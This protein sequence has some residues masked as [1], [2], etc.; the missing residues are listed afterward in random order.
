[1]LCFYGNLIMRRNSACALHWAFFSL[2][3]S[4]RVLRYQASC[5]KAVIKFFVLRNA[6]TPELVAWQMLTEESGLCVNVRSS[7]T[8][9]IIGFII[10][11]V[12]RPSAVAWL[13]LFVA[14]GTW[15]QPE[16]RWCGI[17]GGKK[18]HWGTLFSPSAPVFPYN[19]HSTN[20]QL[21]CNDNN[22]LRI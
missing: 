6:T 19:S 4:I 1:M 13:R 3:M 18:W 17:C 12:N 14:E 11:C 8:C 16:V 20:A 10:T 5:Q 21:S 9:A 22:L 2:L 7:I 15:V